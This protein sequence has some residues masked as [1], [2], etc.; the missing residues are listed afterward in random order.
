M[1]PSCFVYWFCSNIS[2][3][4]MDLQEIK[5][6]SLWLA[7][8]Y[9]YHSFVS[10]NFMPLGCSMLL[11][12]FKGWFRRNL[13]DASDLYSSWSNVSF[14]YTPTYHKSWRWLQI[15]PLDQNYWSYRICFN[16]FVEKS[17]KTT[18]SL[19]HIPNDKFW[20]NLLFIRC[21]R[22]VLLETNGKS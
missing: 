14:L 5:K 11:S 22:H 18:K 17:G 21:D 4:K 10:R 13:F 12:S 2:T 19:P 7:N 9:T 1:V 20:C 3:F 15:R 16:V 8:R 6:S